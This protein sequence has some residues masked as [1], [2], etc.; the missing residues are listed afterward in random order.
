F[1]DIDG[2]GLV[3]PI[4][5]AWVGNT[6]IRMENNPYPDKEL[7]FVKVAYLPKRKQ[8]YGEPDGALLEDNQKVIGAVTRGMI[9]IMA[10]TAAGQTGIRKDMLDAVNRKKYKTGEDYEFNGGVDPRQG[11][12]THV[13]PEI[14]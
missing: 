5:A 1:R 9:D 2:S 6:I 11:V 8:I 4:V 7:P 12:H 14:P 3:T 10:R 13:Y